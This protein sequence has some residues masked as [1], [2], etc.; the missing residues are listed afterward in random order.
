M[1]ISHL[2]ETSREK[3][4]QFIL[5]Y[6][7]KFGLVTSVTELRHL[8]WNHEE[9]LGLKMKMD[10][11][12][13]GRILDDLLRAKEIIIHTVSSI[14]GDMRFIC[15]P[16]IPKDHPSVL[17]AVHSLDLAV[18]K[19]R[20]KLEQLMDPSD[21]QVSVANEIHPLSDE[22][23][24][25]APLQLPHF[26]KGRRRCM[27]HE[28]LYYVTYLVPHDTKPVAPATDEL[29]AAYGADDSWA[30]FVGPVPPPLGLPSG[31]FA[32]N[33]VVCAMPF[34]LYL[35]ILSPPKLPRILFRWLGMNNHLV[36]LKPD[37]LARLDEDLRKSGH[38]DLPLTTL[39]RIPMS[40]LQAP[41]GGSGRLYS[42]LTSQSKLNSMRRAI[43]ELTLHNLVAVLERKTPEGRIVPTGFVKRYASLLDTRYA[44]PGR[45]LLTEMKDCYILHFHFENPSDVSAYWE[46][47]EVI[48][49]YTPLGVRMLNDPL[50]INKLPYGSIQSYRTPEE[51]VDDGSLPKLPWQEDISDCRST[52]LDGLIVAPCGAAGLHPMDFFHRHQNWNVSRRA[53]TGPYKRRR[54]ASSSSS[55]STG[56]ESESIAESEDKTSNRD[57]I[58]RTKRITHT[59]WPGPDLLFE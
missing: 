31:W 27:L 52:T 47:C 57:M 14:Q 13:L 58:L 41:G 18:L 45:Y 19:K 4:R 56:S 53:Y 46:T 33:E 32:M 6:L 43:E 8:I 25:M 29:P 24:K 40:R 11:K 48:C 3:R 20:T 42:W 55:S 50:D 21:E 30:R 34:G 59:F 37:E 5:D 22:S 17:A 23:M 12:S 44:S 2:V 38:P 51:V 36:D 1:Y 7:A 54:P 28:F 10:R 15:S 35:Q 9:S 39:L 49:R 16:T 26:P